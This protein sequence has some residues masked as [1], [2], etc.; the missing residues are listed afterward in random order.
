MHLA[1]V[2]RYPSSIVQGIETRPRVVEESKVNVC[3]G[4]QRQ[5]REPER[6]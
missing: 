2:W 5:D 3:R 4:N 1:M 6:P